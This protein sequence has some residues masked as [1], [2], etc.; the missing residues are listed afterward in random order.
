MKH[1][2]LL[3]LVF[4]VLFLSP[5]SVTHGA[6]SGS[7]PV[8]SGTVQVPLDHEDPTLGS[9]PLHYELAAPFDPALPTI[10]AVT[11][12]Q[13][14]WVRPGAMP[15][16]QERLVGSGVNFVGVLGRARS[17]KIFERI[18]DAEGVVDWTVAYHLLQADQW[19][20]DLEAV[21]HHL[22]GERQIRLYGRSGGALLVHQYLARHGEHVERAFT[23]AAVA[24]P[25]EARLGLR[26]DRF[27][28]QLAPASRQ[29]LLALLEDRQ[30]ERVRI[31]LALQRQNFFVL[32]DKIGQARQELVAALHR[33]D[34]AFFEA[35]CETYQVD[36]VLRMLDT[37]AGIASRIRQYEF[38]MPLRAS[39]QADSRRVSLEAVRILAQPLI[40]AHDAGKIPF[41]ETTFGRAATEVFILAGRQDHTID[42]RSQIALAARYPNGSLFLAD[43]NHTFGRLQESGHYRDLVRAV[44]VHG[45]ASRE[46]RD[47]LEALTPLRWSEWP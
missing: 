25:I 44:L 13:Q 7:P 46:L 37:D 19:V 27:F 36:A 35:A 42:Y 33:K 5:E 20:E 11:D 1:H 26:Y 18:R 23:Q 12:A 17:P 47:T 29:Q 28:E 9:F 31:I 32:P 8:V 16:L 3:N 41:P 40:A 45:Q 6:A 39:H 38:Y 10:F 21:R 4:A 2:A 15:D 24:T 43:D 34:A 22:V 14:F 30:D